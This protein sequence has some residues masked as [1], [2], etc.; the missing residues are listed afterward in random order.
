MEGLSKR[1]HDFCFGLAYLAEGIAKAQR[2]LE[3]LEE[4]QAEGLREARELGKLQAYNLFF[5]CFGAK[6]RSRVFRAA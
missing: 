6:G 4:E 1:E 5:I 3:D 2:K